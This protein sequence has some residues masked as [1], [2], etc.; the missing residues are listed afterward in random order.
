MIV[1]IGAA[2]LSPALSRPV[3]RVL[4]AAF[5]RLFG[6]VGR[7]SRENALRN[8]RRTAA[9]ASALMI[10]LALVGGTSVLASSVNASVDKTVSNSLGAEFIVTSPTS[11]AGFSPQIAATIKETPG[12]QSVTEQRYG[13]AQLGG[14]TTFLSAVDPA[15]WNDAVKLD[16]RSGS[17]AAL[18][19]NGLL[20]DENVAKDRGWRLGQSV[21][22][23][24]KDG[25]TTNLSVAGVYQTNQAAS[26]YLVSLDTL[27][28]GGGAPRDNIVYVKAVG[29]T[30]TAALHKDLDAKLADYPNVTLQDQSGFKKNQQAQVNQLLYLIYALLALSIIIAVLGII[31]TLALSVIERTR[32]IGLLRAVGM[33]RRQLRRMIRLESVVIAVFGALLGLGIGVAFGVALQSTLDEQG[34]SVLSVPAGSLAGFLVLAAV[35]GVLAAIWPARRAARLDVLRAI[36]TE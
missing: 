24:F 29:G 25:T 23:L 6:T 11:F 33:S 3:V 5:P 26:G 1:L 28:R 20:V 7:L 21:P 35:I 31:N 4:G 9:T 27:Q 36:T 34:I 13:Q 10:G 19:G 12:V 16:Y 22:M 32:E 2:V 18:S 8:P 17:A 30:D 14:K 15:T